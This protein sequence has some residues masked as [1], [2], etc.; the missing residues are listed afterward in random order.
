VSV[1]PNQ[2]VHT[3]DAACLNAR[4]NT[5]AL[6]IALDRK[7]RAGRLHWANI[8]TQT[9]TSKSLYT[10]LGRGHRPDADTLIRLLLWLGNTDVAPY[11]QQRGTP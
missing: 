9:G 2:L 6:Y 8:A 1:A 11:I 10:R 3:D 5:E 7:R 4:L